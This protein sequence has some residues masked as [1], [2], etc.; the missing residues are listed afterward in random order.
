MLFQFIKIYTHLHEFF[1]EKFSIN[2]RGLGFLYRRIKKDQILN[3]HG[4]KLFL[5]H[6]I[7]DNYGRL[8]N[9]R[10]NEP[11]THLFLDYVFLNNTIKKFHFIDIGCNIGEFVLDYASR[12]NIKQITAFDPQPEQIKSVKKTIELNGFNNVTL[13]Q[14][15]VSKSVEEIY[16]NFN[17]NNSTASGINQSTKV[18][19]K[20]LSTTIDDSFEM[21]SDF[22][23]VFLIDTEGAELNILKGGNEFIQKVKPLIIFEYNHVTRKYFE[24]NDVKDFL[25]NNYSIYRLRRDGYLDQNFSK[26]WNL[27][28]LPNKSQFSYLKK[29]INK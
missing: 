20:I 26:T 28:A 29:F 1:H 5:N 7:A 8:I 2:I 24:I 21:K 13:V 3:V 10:F 14:K 9:G 11:E 15:P 23:Y 25:G 18:G 22:E 16:F 17:I 19:S 27:V 6:K 12:S 4:K